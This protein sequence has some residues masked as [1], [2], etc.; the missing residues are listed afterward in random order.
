MY[1]IKG[2]DKIRKKENI[3]GRKFG[4]LTVIEE[5]EKRD[6][7]HHCFIKCKCDCG[8]IIIVREDAVKSGNTNSCGC[9][10][11]K[12]SYTRLYA[13]YKHMKNRC[14]NRNNIR[15]KHYGGRGIK[16]CDEW[17]NDFMA[18]YEWAYKN[19]Y[20]DSLSIDRID[21]NGNYE[22]SNCRWATK[23]QQNNNKQNTIYLTLNGKTQT[24]AQWRKELNLKYIT[25][26]NRYIRGLSVGE[27]LQR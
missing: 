20:N 21:V 3:I 9:W 18:F 16:I 10:K 24:I 17:L 6:K 22:P 5:C 8:K 1:G 4:K 12:M 15:Y 11:H 14:H 19:G 2:G 13:I 27:C 7:A 25:V 23:R 26:Y